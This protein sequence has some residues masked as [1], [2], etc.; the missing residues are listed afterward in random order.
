LA[1]AA[2][3]V[4]I[5]LVDQEVML[6]VLVLAV[7]TEESEAINKAVAVAEPIGGVLREAAMVSS[8]FNTKLLKEV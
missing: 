7:T 6:A 5:V 2:V 4:N 1:A 8:L 3:A